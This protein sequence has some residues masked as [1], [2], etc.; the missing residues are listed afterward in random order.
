MK[1]QRSSSVVWI[2]T[3]VLCLGAGTARRNRLPIPKSLIVTD[4]SGIDVI[5]EAEELLKKAK[6]FREDFDMIK[7]IAI[8]EASF[9][10]TSNDGGLWQV[11]K[12]IFRGV[13][14]N[15]RKYRELAA[16]Q[17]LVRRR[18]GITWSRVRHYDLRRPLYSIIAARL[19]LEVTVNSYPRSLT[20]QA[21][22]WS[23]KY[24]RCTESGKNTRS[25]PQQPIRR[26]EAV[27]IKGKF[28]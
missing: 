8:V 19:F 2:A 13:T 17:K 25:P 1:F 15:R 3:L 24:H 20:N 26:S 7:R 11:Q 5:L 6:I 12:C 10:R 18:L 22:L 28:I 16:L 23:H 21:R 14:Q 9:N 27:Y 4:A